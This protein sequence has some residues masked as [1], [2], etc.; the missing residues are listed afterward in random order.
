M[1]TE[2]IDKFKQEIEEEIER[3]H[4]NSLVYVLFDE[5]NTTPFAIHIFYRDHLFMVKSR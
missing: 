5:L 2:Q 1:K 4:Y 3:R